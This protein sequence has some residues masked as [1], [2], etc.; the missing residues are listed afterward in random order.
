FMRAN[1]LTFSCPDWGVG[2]KALC[3]RLDLDVSSLP[4]VS[5]PREDEGRY[6]C[7]RRPVSVG[8]VG[9]AGLQMRASTIVVEGAVRR[10]VVYVQV[11]RG[12]LWP[13]GLDRV[14]PVVG[15]ADVVLGG[16]ANSDQLGSAKIEQ[17]HLRRGRGNECAF[18][19]QDAAGVALCKG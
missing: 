17:R 1:R 2:L 18:D 15:E 7:S 19:V 11:I 12:L 16:V 14:G 5:D 10:V 9:L 13:R 6:P 8:P 3:Q 4:V